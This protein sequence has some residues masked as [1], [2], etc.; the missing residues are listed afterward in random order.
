MPSNFPPA[1][2]QQPSSQT[3]PGAVMQGGGFVRTEGPKDIVEWK[4]SCALHWFWL[5]AAF[6]FGYAAIHY[7]IFMLGVG[8]PIARYVG[9]VVALAAASLGALSVLRLRRLYV[10]YPFGPTRPIRTIAVLGTLC[11]ATIVGSIFIAP[12]L[13]GIGAQYEVPAGIAASDALEDL[14]RFDE[15]GRPY[16]FP[17]DNVYRLSSAISGRKVAE[18]GDYVAIEV[19][20][21]V[22]WVHASSITKIEK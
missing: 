22:F 11:A 20:S 15:S 16:P 6:L 4:T 9:A 12:M 18:S 2:V 5:V 21:K 7:G 19:N 10:Y 14:E 17:Q 8:S 1:P 3:H 13:N